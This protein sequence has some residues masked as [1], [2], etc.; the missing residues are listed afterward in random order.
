MTTVARILAQKGRDV[1][2]TGP[3]FTLQEAARLLNE[4]HIG[5]VVVVE[6]DGSIAGILSERDIV[7]SVGRAGPEALGDRISAHMTRDVVTCTMASEIH[8]LME[9]MTTGKFRHLPVVENGR[10]AGI[11]SIGDVVK[12]RLAEIETEHQALREYIATA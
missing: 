11:V 5:S 9:T 8:F 10:L 6:P 12:H 4:R 1:T 3:D 2:T 7:R